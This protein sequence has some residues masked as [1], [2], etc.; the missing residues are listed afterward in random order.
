VL[1]QGAQG[2]NSRD[3]G[4]VRK[5]KVLV[6]GGR[7]YAD[8]ENLETQMD[9]LCLAYPITKIVHGGARGADTLAGEWAK[10]RKLK[11]FYYQANWELYGK[12]AGRIRNLLML[13][14]EHP[15]LVVAFPGGPGTRHMIKSARKKGV[16]VL[17]MPK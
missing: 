6:C 4:E 7:D 15:T 11:V 17:E 3:P 10:K 1:P 13:E 5:M 14:K 12:S 9:A 2:K 16:E 8:R